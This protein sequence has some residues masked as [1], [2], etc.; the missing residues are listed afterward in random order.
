MIELRCTLDRPRIRSEVATEVGC[1]LELRPSEETTA[2]AGTTALA[3]NLCLVLDCSASML[4]AKVD[5]AIAAA[6]LIVNTI[7]ARH[8]ISVVGFATSH[9]VVVDNA[10]P[11]QTGRDAIN[12]KI[13]KLR[14]MIKG[15]TNLGEGI[16]HGITMVQRQQADAGVLVVLTDG[17]ADSQADAI[18]AGSEANAAGVQVFAVGIGEALRADDL[19]EIV[20]PSGGSLLG[21]RAADRLEAAFAELLKRIESFV[22]TRVQL[23]VSPAAGVTLG[24]IYKTS[25]ERMFVGDNVDRVVVGN[26]ERG[27]VY[28]F[29]V[30][31]TPPTG[32]A[33]E[34]EVAR[35]TLRYDIPSRRLRSAMTEVPIVVTYD[36]R[37]DIVNPEV[38]R[39]QARAQLAVLVGQLAHAEERGD[40]ARSAELLALLADRSAAQGDTRLTSAL[41]GLS[42]PIPQAEL[43]ALMLAATGRDAEPPRAA[44]TGYEI[45]ASPAVEPAPPPPP[46]PPAVPRP[47]AQLPTPTRP[48]ATVR[49]PAPTPPTAPP[50]VRPPV[51]APPDFRPVH[52][53]DP[54]PPEPPPVVQ[55]PP[56]PPPP[57]APPPPPLHEIVLVDAGPSVIELMRELRELTGFGL[58]RVHEL[59]QS[60]P[61]PIMQLPE[62]EA[63]AAKQ[64]LEAHGARV[65]VRDATTA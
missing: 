29:H 27:L 34:V 18:A 35:V 54:A 45:A 19:L 30:G 60:V 25:P 41:R 36:S 43:N 21:E 8:R 5:A 48:S 14:S 13:E 3:T 6:K 32:G 10:S 24:A 1:Q 33:G 16:R 47:R 15:S 38:V 2:V 61:S 11:T 59:I 55:A 40:R 42:S 39:A 49:A 23:T 56:E 44:S 28:A 4:G 9:W 63:R 52:A 26:L 57:P 62:L 51:Q 65:A 53:P 17:V 7:D 37:A 12:A 58:A 64:R 22:A 31:L 50:I 46:P 20:A